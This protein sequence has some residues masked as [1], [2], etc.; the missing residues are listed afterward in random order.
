MP[1][2]LES[3]DYFPFQRVLQRNASKNLEFM[4]QLG[5]YGPAGVRADADSCRGRPGAASPKGHWIHG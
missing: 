2:S 3:P 5:V 1:L 4:A